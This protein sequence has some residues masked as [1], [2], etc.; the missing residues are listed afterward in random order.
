MQKYVTDTNFSIL[1]GQILQKYLQNNPPNDQTHFR[2]NA[3]DSLMDVCVYGMIP[4]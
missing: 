4:T 2:D 1:N 3:A